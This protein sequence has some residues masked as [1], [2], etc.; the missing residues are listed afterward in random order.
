MSYD[1][2][3]LK[4]QASTPI[5]PEAIA[6]Y[7]RERAGYT[8]QN[9]Q[10][11]YEN[12]DTGVYF[13]FELTSGANSDQDSSEDAQPDEI[14]DGL[15]PLGLS[16]NV[17][18]FRPHFF[19]LEAEGEVSALINH[20]SLLVDDPQNQGMGRGEY[21]RDGF[22][23][24]WNAGNVFAHQA[25]LSQPTKDDRGGTRPRFDTLPAGTL[26]QMWAWNFH[27]R[28]LQ[29]SLGE[30]VFVPGVRLVRHEGRPKTFIVWGDAIPE[31]I[32]EV[33]LLVLVRDEMAPRRL[34]SKRKD[35]CLVAFAAVRP[36]LSLARRIDDAVSY[37]LFEY[38]E[39]PAA[40]IDFFRSS[41]PFSEQLDGL[42]YD[43]VLTKEALDLAMSYAERSGGGP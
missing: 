28:R 20:F 4:R 34:F 11:S 7:F 21:S 22:L 31:A 17:N 5:P 25:L 26:E 16:F 36:L 40:L 35:M 29:E 37:H 27:R 2:S 14:A 10:F 19:G 8:I 38:P 9:Q 23:R 1:L 6:Q 13:S 42:A 12:D 41:Q 15:E 30:N 39:P 24:G 3:F 43:G 18:Y 32:P 33:D